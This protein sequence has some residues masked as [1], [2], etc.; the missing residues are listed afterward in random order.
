MPGVKLQGEVKT[1]SPFVDPGSRTIKARALVQDEN[2]VLKPEMSVTV[3]VYASLGTAIAVPLDAVLLTGDHAF[4][5]VEEKEGIFKR[6]EV[7]IGAQAGEFWE[8]RQGLNEQEKVVV[9]GNFLMDS[10]SRLSAASDAS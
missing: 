5:F 7:V 8:I 2:H 10:E 9:N 4:V 1:I 3:F 6:R